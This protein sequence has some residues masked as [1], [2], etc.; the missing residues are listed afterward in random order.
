MKN[1]IKKISIGLLTAFASVS[2]YAQ[3]TEIEEFMFKNGVAVS[4]YLTLNGQSVAVDGLYPVFVIPISGWSELELKASTNNFDATNMPENQRM[5]YWYESLGSVAL[6]YWTNNAHADLG[7]RLFYCNP[8]I[9]ERGWA[10]KSNT[11]SLTE[12]LG[13][14]GGLLETVVVSPSRVLN[15][16]SVPSWMYPGNQNMVWSYRRRTAVA[17]ETNRLGKAVWH[18]IWPVEWRVK[19][20]DAL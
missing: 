9:N 17:G 13:A 11:V 8:D 15:D 18:P 12:M 6:S 20:L 3:R 5:A 1:I 4:N 7:G 2:V 10:M 16:G 19:Q 14:N